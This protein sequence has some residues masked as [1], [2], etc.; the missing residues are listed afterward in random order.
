MKKQITE[1]LE[2]G[3]HK[4][5]DVGTHVPDPPCDYPK[6]AYDVASKVAH[7][8]DARG[9]LVC[10][11]GIGHSI[12]ANKVNGAYAALC[13]NREAAEFSR[14]HNN[15]NILVLGSRFTPASMIPEVV[16]AW[17]STAFDGGRH[18]RRV[19]QIK[20]IEQREFKSEV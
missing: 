7:E 14:A 3:G 6:I 10:M 8:K 4:I 16:N 13:Y 5:V 15:S 20:R 11:T 12:A 17:I 19:N 18:L 9:I 1:Q 2:K